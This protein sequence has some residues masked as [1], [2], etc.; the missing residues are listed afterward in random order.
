M[1]D[2]QYQHFSDD[3][4]VV[5]Y[6]SRE[7]LATLRDDLANMEGREYHEYSDEDRA[8]MKA[9]IADIELYFGM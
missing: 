8:E 1:A 3:D 9:K 5:A 7:L 6:I 2:R 4:E